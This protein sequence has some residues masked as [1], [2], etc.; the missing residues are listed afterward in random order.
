MNTPSV[1]AGICQSQSKA[2]WIAH[3]S[4]SR[5]Q[6]RIKRAVGAAD[7]RDQTDEHAEHDDEDQREADDAELGQALQVQRVGIGDVR[8]FG[9]GGG[10]SC[11]W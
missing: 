2:W 9:C 1:T 8:R 7:P 5:E 3:A 11:C 4:A 6:G 10:S